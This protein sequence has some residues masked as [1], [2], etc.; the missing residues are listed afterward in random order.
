MAKGFLESDILRSV[1]LV[2]GGA[3]VSVR[4]GQNRIAYLSVL[5]PPIKKSAS[6]WGGT[7]QVRAPQSN[8][9]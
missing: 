8:Y 1:S 6:D 9:F 5:F 7:P 3:I 4:A 2:A